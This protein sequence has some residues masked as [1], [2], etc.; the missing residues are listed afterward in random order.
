[1]KTSGLLLH[2]KSLPLGFA[3]PSMVAQITPHLD[4]ATIKCSE[5]YGV[6]R[7]KRCQAL[8]KLLI[9]WKEPIKSVSRISTLENACQLSPSR[10]SRSVKPTA[11]S[12]HQTRGWMDFIGFS[13]QNIQSIKDGRLVQKKTSNS[14]RKTTHKTFRS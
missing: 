6:L 2:P 9:E 8:S 12:T 10:I 4:P 11:I 13:P 14:L 7:P 5:N 1:M 3:Q